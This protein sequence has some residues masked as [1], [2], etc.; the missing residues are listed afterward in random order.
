MLDAVLHEAELT[1]AELDR[2]AFAN[3]PGAFTGVRIAAATAQGIA[4]GLQIPLIGVSTLAVLA[5]QVADS[6]GLD[7]V[8]SMIDARMD[9]AYVGLYRRDA[10]GILRLQGEER[11]LPLDALRC[12]GA[13]YCAGSALRALQ[14]AGLPLPEGDAD[15]LPD[16]AALARI[17]GHLAEQGAGG[18]EAPINYLRNRVAVRKTPT[19]Y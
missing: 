17:A 11:L 3:G 13:V 6:R 19:V 7:A 9:E 8:Q 15:A 10:A 1:R 14:A 18:D 2:L 16:A 5:Q 4:L 12:P